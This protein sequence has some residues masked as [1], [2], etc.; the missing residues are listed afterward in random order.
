MGSDPATRSG[1][2]LWRHLFDGDEFWSEW[3]DRNWGGD[4]SPYIAFPATVA[5]ALEA[6]AE[7]L[8]AAYGR[9][10]PRDVMDALDALGYKPTLGDGDA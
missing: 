8:G 7:Y 5:A 1:V 3:E 6:V 4:R 10:L 9:S 2:P